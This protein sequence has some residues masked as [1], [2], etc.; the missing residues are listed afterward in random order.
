MEQRW[1]NYPDAA[2]ESRQLEIYKRLVEAVQAIEERLNLQKPP[3]TKAETEQGE[4]K[5]EIELPAILEGENKTG[6]IEDKVKPTEPIMI[7]IVSL[8]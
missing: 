2:Q 5:M 6:N 3:E 4:A 1:K 8:R 7:P